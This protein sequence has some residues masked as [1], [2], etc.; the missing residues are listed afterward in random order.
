MASLRTRTRQGI[1]ALAA[2]GMVTAL[3]SAPAT[4][5]PDAE[6]GYDFGTPL[7]VQSWALPTGSAGLIGRGQGPGFGQGGIVSWNGAL[8]FAEEDAGNLGRIDTAGNITEYAM[9][10]EVSNPG[11]GPRQLSGA[12]AAGLWFLADWAALE[13]RAGR[14]NPEGNVDAGFTGGSYV[15]LSSVAA[16]P[17]GGAWVTYRD[18]EGVSRL[19]AD[20]T[21][22]FLDQPRYGGDSESTLGPDGALWLSDG[23]SVIQRITESGSTQNFAAT[24][25][26][27]EIVSMTSSGGSVWYA[28]FNPGTYTTPSRSGLIAKM[29]PSGV[30]TPFASP[31]EDLLP[32]ALTPAADGGVW[33]TSDYGVGHVSPSGSYRVAAMPEGHD[34]DSVA[35]GPDGNLWFTDRDLNQ[36]GVITTAAFAASIASQGPSVAGAGQ[37]RV[38]AKR[39]KIAKRRAVVQVR[40]LKSGQKCSGKVQITK[41]KKTMAK[42]RYVVAVGKKR[43]VRV[44]LTKAGRAF[45]RT[46]RKA[47]LTVVLTST[48]GSS[49]RRVV[50]HRGK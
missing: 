7:A 1:G 6:A 26:Q 39:G 21:S 23:S 34:A 36:V 2:L 32:S 37:A 42:G 20:G 50:F 38:A 49:T 8:W 45:F 18:G 9:P 5:A 31:Y 4:A 44:R 35:V 48:A 46:H 15:R 19:A 3:G 24:G 29:S 13:G 14:L 12:S 16:T 41:R 28:Q 22:T 43:T 10:T 33:F 17:D 11:H 27:G 40:C 25:G 30:A 47:R